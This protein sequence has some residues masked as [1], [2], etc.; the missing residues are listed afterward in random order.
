MP[1]AN[2]SFFGC[3]INRNQKEFRIFKVL[4][5]TNEKY[6]SWRESWLNIIKRTRVVDTDSKRQLQND[7]LHVCEKHFKK[8]DIEVYKFII[9]ILMSNQF[10]Y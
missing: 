2:C 1:G 10:M 6:L 9:C 5:A 3:G 8:E 4:K 7:S